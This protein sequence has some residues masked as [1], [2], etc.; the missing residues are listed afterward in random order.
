MNSN[1]INSIRKKIRLILFLL[2]KPRFEVNELSSKIEM[3]YQ[4]LNKLLKGWLKEGLIKRERKEVLIL[5]GSKYEY[6]LTKKGSELLKELK[7][8]LQEGLNELSYQALEN[9]TINLD[10]ELEKILDD[11]KI[12]LTKKKQAQLI[13]KIIDFFDI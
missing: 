11:L 1:S 5:G 10:Q 6:E 8:L 4:S 3:P 9:K 2:S 13:S 7:T 12:V